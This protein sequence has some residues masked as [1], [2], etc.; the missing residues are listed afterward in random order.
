MH[1]RPKYQKEN[2]LQG[3]RNRFLFLVLVMGFAGVGSPLGNAFAQTIFAPPVSLPPISRPLI[4]G[5]PTDDTHWNIGG[6]N[7]G[8]LPLA[9]GTVS[10]PGQWQALEIGRR[11]IVFG[12]QIDASSWSPP[13]ALASVSR[14]LVI[15]TVQ[16]GPAGWPSLDVSGRP[17]VFGTPLNNSGTDWPWPL[18]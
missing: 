9:I 15:G 3:S 7:R 17:L 16:A 1:S 8:A 10:S 4:F 14:P 13:L 2:N 5:T 18:P 11:P 12:T 6:A